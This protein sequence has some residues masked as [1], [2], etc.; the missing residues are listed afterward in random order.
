[1][2]MAS[3]FPSDVGMSH[4][5]GVVKIIKE[6]GGKVSISK[7]AEESEEDVDDLLPLIESCKMLG[8]VKV[9]RSDIKITA[10]GESLMK[11]SARAIIR[12]SLSG[13]EPFKSSIKAL[14]NGSKTTAELFEELRGMGLF[15]EESEREKERLV[16]L[17]LTWGVRAK[18]FSYD[19]GN[20]TWM[21]VA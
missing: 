15:P 11:G 16:N 14:S 17:L 21:L 13:I 10:K 5:R 2:F 19:S 4:V 6:N 8:F 1:M 3:L 18:L 9:A 7:L 20:E 12:E